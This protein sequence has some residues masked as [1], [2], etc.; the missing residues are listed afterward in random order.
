MSEICSTQTCGGFENIKLWLQLAWQLTYLNPV[1]LIHKP[2]VVDTVAIVFAVVLSLGFLDLRQS[3]QTCV[4]G[5]NFTELVIKS[6]KLN[7]LNHN[8]TIIPVIK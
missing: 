2:F 1:C 6:D 7:S 4:I 8:K 5:S 3:H